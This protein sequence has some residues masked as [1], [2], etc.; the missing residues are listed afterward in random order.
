MQSVIN[1]HG[2]GVEYLVID[3]GSTD[4]TVGLIQQYNEQINYW[5]SEKDGG[6]YDAMNKG[7]LLSQAMRVHINSDDLLLNVPNIKN[8]FQSYFGRVIV[9]SEN[10]SWIRPNGKVIDLRKYSH[11]GFFSRKKNFY[12][13]S[14]KI[15]SDTKYMQNCKEFIKTDKIVSVFRMN[16]I[17]SKIS[18]KIPEKEFYLSMENLA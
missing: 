5:V 10:Y 13:T 17:S 12:D 16:G 7:V 3:G 18:I 4:G 9:S 11:Q 15:S 8:K 1:Q 6:I 14:C 2:D